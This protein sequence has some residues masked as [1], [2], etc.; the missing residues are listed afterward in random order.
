LLRYNL[1]PPNSITSKEEIASCPFAI[2]LMKWYGTISALDEFEF[3]GDRAV[4][5]C[6][7]C[8]N[9]HYKNV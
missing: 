3:G 1:L 2:K 5:F 6:V 9:T 8:T 4:I 7:L